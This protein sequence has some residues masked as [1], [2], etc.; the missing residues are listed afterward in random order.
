MKKLTYIFY[1]NEYSATHHNHYEG[2]TK[3]QCEGNAC[4][5][6]V[7]KKWGS[8]TSVYFIVSRTSFNKFKYEL[9]INLI[10]NPMYGNISLKRQFGIFNLSIS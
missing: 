2:D 5:K 8:N 1:S 4:L 6:R 7:Y 3:G 9:K 10:L